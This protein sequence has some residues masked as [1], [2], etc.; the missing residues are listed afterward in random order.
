MIRRFITWL[1][2]PIVLEILKENRDNE[3]AENELVNKA[4]L[5]ILDKS[6]SAEITTS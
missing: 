3:L 4:L 2:K 5:K 6:N 1:I